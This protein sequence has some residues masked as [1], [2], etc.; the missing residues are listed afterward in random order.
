MG[1]K[2]HKGTQRQDDVKLPICSKMLGTKKI[3]A[4]VLKLDLN[5]SLKSRKKGYFFLKP[6]RLHM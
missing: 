1:K 2:I 4:R 5:I 3:T 6:S